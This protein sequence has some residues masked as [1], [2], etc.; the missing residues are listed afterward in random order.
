MVLTILTVF[1]AG[2]LF[3]AFA[4]DKNYLSTYPLSQNGKIWVKQIQAY[5]HLICF[6]QYFRLSISIV[7]LF[8]GITASKKR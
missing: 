6:S 8:C 1:Q 3:F 5:W 7:Y 2:C 4:V